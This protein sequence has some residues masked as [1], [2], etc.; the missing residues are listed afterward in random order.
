M[1][2]ALGLVCSAAMYLSAGTTAAMLLGV[3]SGTSYDS[4]V[5]Y[6]RLISV[7][8]VFC[9][10]GNAFAGH[11][12][13]VGRVLTTFAGSLVHITLR[14]VFSWLWLQQYGLDAV[15][16]S[17]GSGWVLVNLFW[18]VLYLRQSR[19]VKAR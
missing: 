10:T 12:N 1:L 7:F 19:K 4:A 3:R 16:V 15:A 14:A 17:A 13:G 5:S 8:Y 6:L 11:F 18:A 9:F 2:L